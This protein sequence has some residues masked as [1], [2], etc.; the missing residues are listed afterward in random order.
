MTAKIY[1]KISAPFRK[2]PNAVR[3]ME[4]LNKVLTAVTYVAYILLLVSQLVFKI[5]NTTSGI[6]KYDE[7]FWHV[8]FVPAIGF[9]VV[10]LFRKVCN[11]KRPY[12][13]L[14]IQPLISRNKEGQSFPSRHAFSI[15]MIAM[16]LWQVWP[17]V[18]IVFFVLG[19]LLACVRVI[20]GVHFPRDVIAG[21][22]IAVAWG[23]VGFSMSMG[24][25]V[26]FWV[27]P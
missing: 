1:E 24:H 26:S 15:F 22:V 20:G 6:A 19:V 10:T 21:A 7:M 16:A 18:G 2:N 12:E 8:L 3:C 27:K 14:D 13:V 5:L 9:I 25:A 11:A 23:L 17:P 4:L